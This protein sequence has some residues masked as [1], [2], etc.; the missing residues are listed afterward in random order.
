MNMKTM[1][2]CAGVIAALI[3]I[4]LADARAQVPAAPYFEIGLDPVATV[5]RPLG[6]LVSVRGTEPCSE[7]Y[8]G[9]TRVNLSLLGWI[10]YV[11]DGGDHGLGSFTIRSL[12]LSAGLE[13]LSSEWLS[14]SAQYDAFDD[15]NGTYVPVE[16]EFATDYDL[17]YL[18]A[19]LE[20]ESSIGANITV[21][22]GPSVA[23]AMSA[24]SEQ[25]ESI[26][27][28]SSATFLDRTQERAIADA[29]GAIDDAGV[30]VGL[31]AAVAYR[32]PLG[33]RL[34]FEPTAGVDVGLTNVQ[35]D[36][37]P[38]EL[39][40]G[41]SI[42]YALF[43]DPA[44]VASTPEPV[45]ERPQPE[46]P[47]PFA[48]TVDVVLAGDRAI[49]LRR[50][51]IARYTPV[52]PVVFF[53]ANNAALPERYRQLDAAAT[54][55]FAESA[56]ASAADVA[57]RDVLNVLGARLRANPRT[58][59][60]LTGTTSEEEADRD[61]LA[62]GRA[63]AV[64]SYL[65]KQWSLPRNRIAVRS[66]QAPAV[67]TSSATEEGRAENRRVE[68]AISD[69]SLLSPVQQRSVEPV[70]EPRAIAFTPVVTANRPIASWEL[71]VTSGDVKRL[72]GSGAPP[73]TITWELDQADR[74]RM[75]SQGL[76]SYQ[77]TVS[78]A[79]GARVASEK[80]LL[81]LRLDTTVTV[82]TSSARPDNAAE[83]LLITFEFDQARLTERG[84]RDRRD[85]REPHRTRIVGNGDRLHRSHRRG[86]A[87][88]WARE[89]ARRTGRRAAP[90]GR[91]PRRARRRPERGAVRERYAGRP[92]PEPNGPSGDRES[93]VTSATPRTS[94]KPI[95]HR[96]SVPCRNDLQLAGA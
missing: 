27:A 21:R 30:R 95:H 76:A 66:R 50:Q 78:S 63:E 31:G 42:G 11:L 35:P 56:I 96:E 80:R 29:T 15:V 3:G 2:R 20:L 24:S 43:A 40:L 41:I 23:V 47:A 52:I 38:L 49:E 5:T 93:E 89:G 74:E 28:P 45:V 67:P 94:S 4:F 1:M 72:S 77:L 16:T 87:Q 51:I 32:L 68:I 91:I 58:T 61:A 7:S 37:T 19:A 69:E 18:R 71:D 83:F 82:A 36:W 22:F 6:T 44:P 85:D 65:E 33:R 53:D 48:A 57:H 92:I 88:P 34:F 59:V 75:L 62:R 25:R 46:R 54:A 55:T 8:D 9:S 10:G 86:R 79:D 26:V 84:R 64:A 39:R 13:D 70:S 60:T 17:K 81:P 14:P 12:R 73:T 90:E